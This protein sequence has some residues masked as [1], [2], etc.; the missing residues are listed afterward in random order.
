MET[1]VKDGSGKL[2]LSGNNTYFAST[3]VSN[4]TLQLAGTLA[5]DLGK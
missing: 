5:G 2:I 4:G 1:V 3:S